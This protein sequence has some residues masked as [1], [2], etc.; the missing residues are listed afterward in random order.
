MDGYWPSSSVAFL[1][2]ETK[3]GSIKTQKKS[4][5]NIQPSWPN[6]FGQERTY[7]LQSISS[8]FYLIFCLY[9]SSPPWGEKMNRQ[10]NKWKKKAHQFA[11]IVI[12]HMNW[13]SRWSEAIKESQ[14]QKM[15]IR[16]CKL[17]YKSEDSLIQVCTLLDDLLT[18]SLIT[19]V[20]R[21][22]I[23][24]KSIVPKSL[25]QWYLERYRSAY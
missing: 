3:S 19:Q 16:A 22:H 2:T 12:W 23:F 10:I 4:K 24:S 13:L 1:W 14:V 21:I 11:L 9:L 5:V 20:L 18:R 25:S 7:I 6:K 15:Y 17:S 8:R